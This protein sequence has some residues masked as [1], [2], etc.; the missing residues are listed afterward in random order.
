MMGEI[1][2]S[3]AAPKDEAKSRPA[4]GIGK[5]EVVS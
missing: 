4:T 2:F 1:D 3:M 5:D